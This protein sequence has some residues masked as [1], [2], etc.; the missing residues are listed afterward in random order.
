MNNLALAQDA[1]LLPISVDLA[2]ADITSQNLES[3]K[4]AQDDQATPVAVSGFA[5]LLADPALIRAVEASG[6][7]QPTPVQALAIPAALAGRDLIV[8][9]QTGSGKTAAFMLPALQRLSNP[10]V[11]KGIG[12]RVLVLAPTR[13]LADQ[14]SKAAQTYGKF[15]S[16]LSVLSIVGGMP[17]RE[18]LQRLSRPV[19]VLIAT[20]G[21][22]LDHLTR[23]RLNFD[24]LEVLVLDEA[25]RMLDMGFIEDIETLVSKTPATRQ[26]LLF[27]ATLAEPVERLAR[28]WM[29]SPERIN[30]SAQLQHRPDIEERFYPS[31]D[32]LHKGQLLEQFITADDVDQ[33][34]IFIATK[35]DAD[36]LADQLCDNGFPAEPLHGD[37]DQKARNRTI[38]KMKRGDV[39]ILVAT[40]VAAR[41]IDV[42]GISHVINWDLPM[43]EEDYV[44]RIGRT[45]RAGRK[46]TAITFVTARDVFKARAIERFVQRE[47][48]VHTIAGMEPRFNPF[49][50]KGGGGARSNGGGRNAGRGNGGG[51]YGGGGDK[52]FANRGGPN[53]SFGDRS[54][55]DRNGSAGFGDRGNADRSNGGGFADR[56]SGGG[57]FARPT[58]PADGARAS[59]ADR[60]P[61]PAFADRAP[62][63]AF[64]DRGAPRPAFADRGTRPAFADRPRTGGFGAPSSG[65]RPP[66]PARKAGGVR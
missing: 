42:A 18:Q 59:F 58:R 13:E 41:G 6:Y 57:G 28:Q 9:S 55:S 10:P 38:N 11:G 64:A 63:P 30:I 20:P 48:P 61:K 46:G 1:S 8:S 54:S 66:R 15:M 16:R 40:D 35:R 36:M 32:A 45:G 21:R 60:A 17:Y 65:P 7:T 3:T 14:S 27:S 51:G 26:T 4:Q 50:R 25:D 31:D 23:G 44:H 49:D 24:R 2:S 5:H 22:L 19:D 53:K 62:R 43:H 47:I 37:M 12:P 56:N 33:M 39:K 34:I 52:R 29:K